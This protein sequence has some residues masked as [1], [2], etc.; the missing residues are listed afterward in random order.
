MGCCFEQFNERFPLHRKPYNFPHCNGVF[1]RILYLVELS[2]V[3]FSGFFYRFFRKFGIHHRSQF[4]L[5]NPVGA[6][7]ELTWNE[8][9]PTYITTAAWSLFSLLTLLRGF[10]QGLW[11]FIK[12]SRKVIIVIRPMSWS[13]L[14]LSTL[15]KS[16]FWFWCMWYSDI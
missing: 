10:S 15:W 16:V 1:T 13:L 12:I 8:S 5:S 6:I 9:L 2:C 7:Q 11:L 14:P 4:F 3:G